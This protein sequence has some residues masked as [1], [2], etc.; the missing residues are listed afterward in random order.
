MVDPSSVGERLGRAGP[1]GRAGRTL[2]IGPYRVTLAGL[3]DALAASL[4]RRWGGFLAPADDESG[5]RTAALEIRDAGA[6]PWLPPR[7]SG[8]YR[9]ELLDDGTVLSENFAL[10]RGGGAA[11]WRVA[12]SRASE[13]A[14]RIVENACR[15][16]LTDLV[17]EDGGMALHG[18]GVLH[19]RRAWLLAGKSRAGKS[20]AVGLMAPPGVSLGDDFALLWPRGEGWVAPAVPFDNSERVAGRPARGVFPL[21]GVWRLHQ[22]EADRLERIAPPLAE[23]SLL[24]SVAF[25]WL[26]PE[27]ASELLARAQRL[28]AGGLFA[29]LHFRRDGDPWTVLGSSQRG[30]V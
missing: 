30:Q 15:I 10:A 16:V 12:V 13:P 2:T 21:A 27:R 17:L 8:V 5:G 7:P 25:P 24:A 6:A 29:H 11:P 22:A 23:A 19:D 26:F 20:T 4:D 18:A 9:L 14:E 1:P 3:D 28:C